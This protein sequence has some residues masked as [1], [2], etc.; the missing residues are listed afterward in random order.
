MK[1][2]GSIVNTHLRGHILLFE[3]PEARAW[4]ARAGTRLIIILVFLELVLDPRTISW[5][6]LPVPSPGFFM[7]AK[8]AFILWLVPLYAGVDRV[9]LGFRRWRD[10]TK[11][12]SSYLVQVLILAGIIF[13]LTLASQWEQS[14]AEHGWTDLA[15]MGLFPYFAFGFYQEVAYRGMLQTELI[16]RWG[17]VRGILAGNALYTLGPVHA[18]Y[19]TLGVSNAISLFLSVF[20]IGLLFAMIF[21]RSGNLWIVAV[22]HGA[23]NALIAA[24]MGNLAF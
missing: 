21:R 5:L 3:N 7:L 8:L 17:A 9:R 20:A 14:L 19:Y 22:M 2:I 13:P 1:A 24:G 18:N 23:G 10:W 16:R 6:P 15:L 11:T 4:P 12:E